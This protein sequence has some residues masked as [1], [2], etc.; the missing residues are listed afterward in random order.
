MYVNSS[1]QP[2]FKSLYIIK[3]TAKNVDRASTMIRR[4]CNNAYVQNIL[5]LEMNMAG[6]EYIAPKKVL[7][8]F[9]NC[10]YCY[11]TQVYS[12]TQPLVQNLIATNEHADIVKEYM[13]KKVEESGFSQD[14]ADDI[15]LED[16]KVMLIDKLDEEADAI[17]AYEIAEEQ[18]KQGDA[19]PLTQFLLDTQIKA[20]DC[21]ANILRPHNLSAK[22]IRSISAEDIITAF[23]NR[24]FDPILGRFAEEEDYN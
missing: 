24:Q 8:N 12:A 6:A 14:E 21:L 19:A 11:L 22:N 9:T 3:G 15:N 13:L 23:A 20:K 18:C 1:T 2:N 4:A 16:L 7:K 17:E 10:D 5:D